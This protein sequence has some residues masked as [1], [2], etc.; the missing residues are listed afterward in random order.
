LFKPVRFTRGASSYLCATRFVIGSTNILFAHLIEPTRAVS[1]TKHPH[2]IQ[3][4]IET[5][6]HVPSSAEWSSSIASDLHLVGVEKLSLGSG[7]N[8]RDSTKNGE[9]HSDKVFAVG[10]SHAHMHVHPHDIAMR[11]TRDRAGCAMKAQRMWN[12]GLIIEW[13]NWVS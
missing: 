5:V 10:V 2:T 12:R 4:L 6:L 11:A 8:A 1:T 13:T 9:S 7:V 3:A